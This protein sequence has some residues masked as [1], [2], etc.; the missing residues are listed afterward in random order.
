MVQTHRSATWVHPLVCHVFRSVARLP[1]SGHFFYHEGHEEHEGKQST[2]RCI[3]SFSLVTL[4]FVSSPIL[5]PA[6]FI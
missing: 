2:S 1:G 5:L 4:K 3:P 6:H